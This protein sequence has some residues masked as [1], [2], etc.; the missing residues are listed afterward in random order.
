CRRALSVRETSGGDDVDVFRLDPAEDFLSF[1]KIV[2]LLAV[3]RE[4]GA[5]LQASLHGDGEVIHGALEDFN[6]DASWE[7]IQTT[8]VL[9][10]EP[11]FFRAK[12]EEDFA[13]GGVGGVLD[14]EFESAFD[15]AADQTVVAAEN[16]A[17][18]DVGFADECGDKA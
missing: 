16:V 9:A 4:Q 17:L 1:V 14:A 2:L 6:G 8:G 15:P 10:G 7:N 11:D 3:V 13:G 12:R 5:E 18:D